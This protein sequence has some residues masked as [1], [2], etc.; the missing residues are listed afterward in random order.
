MTVGFQLKPIFRNEFFNAGNVSYSENN[1]LYT[2]DPRIG[3]AGGMIIRSDFGKRFSFET[4]INY[5]RRNYTL[6]VT[7]QDSSFNESMNFGVV[8]YEIPLLFLVYV[9]FFRPF[10]YMTL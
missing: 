6:L 10:N 5:V 1:V 9:Y 3:F 4:G 7:D 2:V 8:E